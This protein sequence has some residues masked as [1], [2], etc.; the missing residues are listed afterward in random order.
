MDLLSREELRTLIKKPGGQ[1]VSIYIPTHRTSPETKQ[2]PIRFKNLLRQAEEE[3]KKGGLRPSDAKTFLKPARA[4]LKNGFFWQYQSDGL[5]AFISSQGFFHYRLPLQFDEL[6]FVADRF[7]IKPLLPVFTHEARFFILALSQN[8]VRFFDCTRYSANELE[9]EGV[10]KSMSEA[11]KY[12]EPERQL[13][14]HTRTPAGAGERAAMFHGQGVGTDDAKTNLLRYFHRIDD[15]LRDI[16]REQR[17]PLVLAGVEYLL[18]IYKEANSYP[19]V[20]EYGVTGN[21]EETKA[22]ELHKQ[23]WELVEPYFRKD[24]EEAMARYKSLAG[25]PRASNS[26][27]AIVTS[28]QDG[29]IDVLFVPVGVQQWGSYDPDTRTVHLH[30]EAEPGDED[31]LD[32][33]AVHTFLSGGTVYAVRPEEMPDEGPAAAVLRY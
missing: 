8:E 7:H 3:L 19:H 26:L 23:A 10:P 5:A 11:L 2:D 22:E 12:D 30:P 20:M 17:S 6:L 28:A 29:R 16:L 27:R 14:F 1:C 32:L 21:P 33:A 24:R 25:S 13:Q 4:L 31:L 9:L 18:P 15:G